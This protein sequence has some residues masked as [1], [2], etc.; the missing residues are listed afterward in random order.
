VSIFSLSQTFIK[1]G[2]CTTNPVLKVAGF[3]PPVAV[4]PFSPGG[5]SI[6]SKIQTGSKFTFI[7]F[8]LNS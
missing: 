4:S 7:G 8:Q 3:F 1:R 6:T 2:T 5:V